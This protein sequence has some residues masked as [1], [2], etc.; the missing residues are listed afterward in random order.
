MKIA[1]LVQCH[2]N[3]EQVNMLVSAFKHEHIDVF[4]HVDK[5]S[6]IVVGNTDKVYFLPNEM[7]VDVEWSKYSQVE[8]SLNLLK[9]AIDTD[10]YDYYWLISGQDFPLVNSDMLID[11]FSTERKCNYIDISQSRNNGAT[12]SNSL[13]KRNDIYYPEWMLNKK[14]I[15]HIIKRMWVELSGGYNKTYRLFRRKNI[16]GC[17]FY[18]GSSWWCISGE[19]ANYLIDYID[20]HKEYCLFFK[21]CVCSDESFFQTLLMNSPYK[22]TRQE[23]PLYVEWVEGKNNPKI[24]ETRDYKKIMSSGNIIARKFD[25]SV[26]RDIIEKIISKIRV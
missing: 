3:A 21:N 1:V 2:K 16:T 12:K 20:T 8:A 22:D 10:D 13:D 4:I 23:Y 19:F 9:Y 7:R 17:D 24:L 6:T 14:K 18:F 5:K 26:D 25:I 15:F 11:F